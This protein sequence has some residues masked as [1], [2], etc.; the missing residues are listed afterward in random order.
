MPPPTNCVTELDH[1]AWFTA[2]ILWRPCPLNLHHPEA[3]AGLHRYGLFFRRL[4]WNLGRKLEVRGNRRFA[5]EL[6]YRNTRH[7]RDHGNKIKNGSAAAVGDPQETLRPAPSGERRGVITKPEPSG[8]PGA[9]LMK[10]N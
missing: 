10:L 8:K 6:P 2:H 7:T 3:N 5:W 4:P 9:S 1:R